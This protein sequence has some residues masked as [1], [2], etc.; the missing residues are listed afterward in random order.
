MTPPVR[1]LE[2]HDAALGVWH[3]AGVEDRILVH[4]DAHHDMWWIDDERST[5]AAN[6]LCPAI[7]RGM[8]REIY[9]VVPDGAFHTDTARRA[10]HRQI[11]SMLRLH[12]TGSRIVNS[13]TASIT[14]EIQ[15]RPLTICTA[16]TLPKIP[17]AVVLD[18]DVDYLVIPQVSH[19]RADIHS[20]PP[21][22]WPAEVVARLERADVRASVVTIAYSVEGCYTP[23]RWKYFGD[24]LAARLCDQAGS[25]LIEG[26]ERMRDG[27]TALED[28]NT[29]RAQEHYLEAAR[30]LPG[31]A[32]PEH[33]LAL[34]HLRRGDPQSA[35]F[36]SARARQIDPSY[37]TGF[38]TLGP[39]FFWQG[40]HAEAHA[41]FQDAL[42][43]NP[44]DPHAA[45]GMAWI[46]AALRNTPADPELP[47]DRPP[48]EETT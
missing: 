43:L 35:Q 42:I 46:A 26:F 27:V 20:D 45:V 1:V 24:E 41:E 22:R 7:A 39:H 25:G 44:L 12:P 9:W 37:A 19:N 48:G 6:F 17:D 2:L 29:D 4:L 36:H 30:L 10:L 33:H 40:R 23:L 14:A 34:L 3:E 28:A 18:I 31:C 5:T 8:F 38:A 21:W 11:T 16:D 15:G 47:P 13:G 32:A